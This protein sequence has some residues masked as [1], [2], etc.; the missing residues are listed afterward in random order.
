MSLGQAV[1]RPLWLQR[2]GGRVAGFG[3][4]FTGWKKGSPTTSTLLRPIGTNFVSFQPMSKIHLYKELKLLEN[5]GSESRYRYVEDDTI[6]DVTRVV[7]YR[8]TL[9]L[10]R[11][12]ILIQHFSTIRVQAKTELLKT[13]FFS[14]FKKSD[15]KRYRYFHNSF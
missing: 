15:V 5:L 1:C 2:I 8:L 12:Q 9:V 3:R 14:N 13:I 11:I 4:D 10:F 7:V 6:G